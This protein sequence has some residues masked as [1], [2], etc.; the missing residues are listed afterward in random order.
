MDRSKENERRMKMNGQKRKR[1][2]GSNGGREDEKKKHVRRT[3][4]K[5]GGK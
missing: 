2:K 1:I 5:E 4:K 3:G